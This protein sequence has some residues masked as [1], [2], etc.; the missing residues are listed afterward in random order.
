MVEIRKYNRCSYHWVLTHPRYPRTVELAKESVE[1]DL[2]SC[3]KYHPLPT[4]PSD[5]DC[6]GD[7]SVKDNDDK[8]DDVNHCHNED[9]D[10]SGVV[11]YEDKEKE[12]AA[13]AEQ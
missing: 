13:L 9:D 11:D 3:E 10:G 5:G 8:N 6:G 7:I 1:S 12:G 4:Q 2:Q